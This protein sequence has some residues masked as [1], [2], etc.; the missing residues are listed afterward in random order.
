MAR[1]FFALV[2]LLVDVKYGSSTVKDPYAALYSDISSSSFGVFER[3]R[4]LTDT[5]V[6]KLINHCDVPDLQRKLADYSIS[7]F[8]S[9]SQQTRAP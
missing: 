2:L 9:N 7:S 6:R 3:N 4:R 5:K 1:I 8:L